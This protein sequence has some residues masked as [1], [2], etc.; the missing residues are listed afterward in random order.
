[1]HTTTT[2]TTNLMIPNSTS[3]MDLLVSCPNQAEAMKLLQVVNE[4]ELQLESMEREDDD[5]FSIMAVLPDQGKLSSALTAF[6]DANCEYTLE[7]VTRKK[8]ETVDPTYV[9]VTTDRIWITRPDFYG[10]P[11]DPVPPVTVGDPPPGLWETTSGSSSPDCVEL[12]RTVPDDAE[13]VFTVS[14]GSTGRIG[15]S[16]DLGGVDRR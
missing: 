10:T 4:L 7:S 13:S 15:L 9:P 16:L 8:V 11:G 5:T 2:A 14:T 12:T 1:M 3:E 6:A